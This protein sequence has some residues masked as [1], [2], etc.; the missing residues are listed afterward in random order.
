MFDFSFDFVCRESR[1]L[2]NKH[3][4]SWKS[5]MC[6]SA[7]AIELSSYLCGNLTTCLHYLWCIFRFLFK[8]Q[9]HAYFYG[10]I[11][12]IHYGIFTFRFHFDLILFKRVLTFQMP[13]LS[14]LLIHWWLRMSSLNNKKHLQNQRKKEHT[15]NFFN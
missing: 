14:H 2:S 12:G 10:D 11:S 5:V 9:E 8:F 7:H 6:Y 15:I 4:W 13:P 1:R 3:K